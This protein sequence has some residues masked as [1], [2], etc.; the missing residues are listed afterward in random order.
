MRIKTVANFLKGLMTSI[1]DYSIPDGAAS[2]LLNWKY[3]GDKIEL[4]K[5][6]KVLGTEIAGTGVATG[7][8]VM[9]KAN[10]TQ[11]LIRKRGRKLEYYDTT[12][13]DWIETSTANMFPAA[14]VDDEA[15]F[16]NYASLAGNQTFITTPNA[17]PFKIMSANPA[18]FTDLT[19]AAKNFQGYIKIKQNRMFLWGRKKDK[20][21]I[22]GSYIDVANATTV[23]GENIGTGDGA[24]VTFNDTL[25]FK[26][27][28][29]VRTCFGITATDGTETF[30]DNYDGTLTGS[31][32]GTGTINYTTGAISVTFAAAPTNLQAITADYQ[33]ENSNNAGITDFT[34]SA[35]RTAGQGFIFRQDDD[36]GDAKNVLSYGD[37]EY[38]MHRLKTWALTLTATDTNATNLIYRDHVGI[39]NWRA[40]VETGD[41]VYYVDDYDQAEPKFRLL[42]LNN[43]STQVI[44]LPISDQLNLIDYRFDKAASIEYGDYVLFACRHKDSTYNNAVFAFNKRLK[45]WEKYDYFVACFVIYNGALVAGESISYNVAE[46]FSGFDDNTATIPNYWEGNL[47]KLEVEELKRLK[48]FWVQG[49]ISRDQSLDI[50]MAFDRGPYILV[51]TQNG[52]DDN[53]D[54]GSRTVI[55]SDAIGESTL[56]GQTSTTVY[57]YIKEIKLTQGKFYEVKVKFE[58]TA[59]GYCSVSK[60]TYHDILLKGFKLPLRYRDN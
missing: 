23:T 42:T 33:W 44:P 57:N 32:G 53:V 55:G 47:T 40:A 4:R 35:T 60:Y 56:G 22:Y 18:S 28:G 31:A 11:V 43:V 15:S 2:S 26:A 52:S 13:S 16:D 49:E 24:T 10:G 39:P 50:Y 3:T 20:T 54:S 7:L 38:C 19:D 5:G 21:G 48:R 6:Y 58:A 17:G 34:K 1:E 59:L 14:A 36:G 25:A 12:T 27:G 29:A 37:V 51:G 30:T 46:L 45:L 8:H 41:G 9:V